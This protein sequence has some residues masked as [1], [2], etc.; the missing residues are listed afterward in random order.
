MA[1]TAKKGHKAQPGR[2]GQPKDAFRSMAEIEEEFFP[3]LARMRRQRVESVG[4]SLADK[5]ISTILR[6]LAHA[7]Q[8]G[9]H[10]TSARRK[11]QGRVRPATTT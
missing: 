9:T 11:K 2:K 6:Q 8:K 1:H 3:E 5:F 4:T 10:H 7:Q